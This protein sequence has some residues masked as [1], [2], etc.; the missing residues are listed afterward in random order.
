MEQRIRILYKTGFDLVFR[1]PQPFVVLQDSPRPLF[2]DRKALHSVKKEQVRLFG[3]PIIIGDEVM[4]AI[5]VDRLF[6]EQVPLVEDVQFLSILASFIA[7][8]L[9]LESQAKRGKKR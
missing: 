4:G 1:I 6:G 2:L 8:V 7:Q 3:S 5:M 9:S